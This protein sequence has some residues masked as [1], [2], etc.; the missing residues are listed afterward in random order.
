VG[1]GEPLTKL[2]IL[3]VNPP[4]GEIYGKLK[5]PVQ[6]H[7]GLAYLAASV[8]AERV[9]VLDMDAEKIGFEAFAPLVKQSGFDL[10]GFTVT[11]PA[12]Y[13]SL[14]LAKIVKINSPETLVVFGGIHPTVS[15]AEVLECP[16][17]D[18]VVV[19]EGESALKEIVDCLK[20]KKRFSGIT[21][22]AFRE[23]GLFKQS[24]V[25]PAILNLDQLPFPS[26]EL[27]KNKNYTYPDSLYRATFPIMTSRGC[28]GMCAYCMS[29]KVC[30]R[31]FRP[32][33]AKN[34]VD[35]IEL[36]VDKWKAKE[37]HIWDDNF[38]TDKQRVFQIRDELKKRKLRV[39]F[40]FPNGIRADFLNEEVLRAL[41]E[42][43]AYSLAIGV[44]SGS[45]EVL[46]LARKGI[47]LAKIEEAFKLAKKIGLETW[48]FFM[49][50]LPG[51]SALTIQQTIDFAKKLDPDIAKF[52]ILKPFPG[53]QVYDYLKER[54]FILT[55]NYSQFGFHTPPIHRLETLCPEDMLSWQKKAY[56]SFY[57]R[58][59][60]IFQ[61]II[62]A[63][64][65]NRLVLNL[66]AGIGLAKMV[67]FKGRSRSRVR[68]I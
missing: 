10:I 15:P 25:R 49:I 1:E 27:F 16:E 45:Q 3:L 66:G 56:K 5:A 7:M 57:F 17:V 60:K 68:P 47:R 37:V 24:P 48:A 35:E 39:K 2:K 12:L 21:G 64:T 36:L 20:Q 30:G 55:Q 41:K 59:K 4:Q 22:I 67:I 29:H 40:A 6:M 38:T 61:Q 42:M 31:A 26:R 44:E 65:L 23:N 14:K 19:G 54:N 32:R 28:P 18:L 51:E 11:T 63:K 50:G 43:G 62:R 13:S 9:Q 33:S 34:V 46:N 58:P 8:S 52:H 53:S